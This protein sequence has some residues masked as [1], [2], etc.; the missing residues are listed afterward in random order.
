[1]YC[2]RA[3]GGVCQPCWIPGANATESLP[4]DQRAMPRCPWGVLTERGDYASPSLHPLCA[5]NLPRDLCCLYSASCNG[6]LA[7]DPAPLTEDG[8]AYVAS[9]QS[10]A[11]MAEF[12]Q[13]VALDRYQRNVTSAGRLSSFAYWLWGASPREASFEAV[14]ATLERLV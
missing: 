4:A 1:M 6:T 14:S 7:S 9:K 13:R 8:F 10:T 3:W 5:S 2:T 11:A 12:L